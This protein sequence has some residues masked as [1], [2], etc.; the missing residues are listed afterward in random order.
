MS[1][2]QVNNLTNT[3]NGPYA[4]IQAAINDANTVNGDIL[5]VDPGTYNG[6]IIVNKSLTIISTG[7]KGVTI[8]NGNQAGSEL[9]TF[10][11]PNGVNNVQIGDLSQGFTINGIDGPPGS[12]KAAIYFQGAH[13][14]ITIKG[15]EIVA[16]GDEG[17]LSEYNAAVTFITIDNNVFSGQTFL[18]P[19]PAGVGFGAQFT[20]ANV[21]RQLVVM[22]GGSSGT[23]TTDITFTNNTVNGVAGGMSIT[24]NN[25]N[26]IAPTEQGNT[27]VTIDANNSTITGNTFEGTTTRYGASLRARRP[28]TALSS[29]T[30]ISTG[31]TP[32]TEH[33]FT[34]NNPVTRA[35]VDANSFDVGSAIVNGGDVFLANGET[36]AALAPLSSVVYGVNGEFYV[37]GVLTIQNT[38]SAE[39]SCR[40]L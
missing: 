35:L 17:L 1:F 34:Q 16:N 28:L 20:L 30:F 13:T 38:I 22:G 29:N 19:N 7:G 18:G 3:G 31:L 6:N 21:P 25:G 15:N 24:D 14:N 27:L 36:V 32:T 37:G 11:I 26:P 8:V 33:L 12:E 2:A 23:N 9:G 40:N 5:S 10:V 39:R 4:T